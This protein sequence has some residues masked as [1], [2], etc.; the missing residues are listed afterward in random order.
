MAQKTAM[1]AIQIFLAFM[2]VCLVVRI[3]NGGSGYYH[4]RAFDIFSGVHYL[5]SVPSRR[6]C[7]ENHP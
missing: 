4:F 6:I 7:N 5:A 1:M 2:L 3:G